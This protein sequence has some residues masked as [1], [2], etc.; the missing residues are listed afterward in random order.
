M[1]KTKEIVEII[2]SILP[3]RRPIE[4]HEPFI[5][6]YQLK[7]T[8][9][10][11]V[12]E[13]IL[14]HN[15]VDE[16]TQTISTIT[17]SE[18]C[19]LTN[20]GTAALEVA[21]RV[22]DVKP[23]EEVIVPS[24]TFVAT[25]NAVSHIGAVPH[26]V[27]G[28]P[29]LRAY[30]LRQYLS[31]KTVPCEG[32][33]VYISNRFEHQNNRRKI[34]AIVVVH[35]FGIP[36]AIEDICQV[37][38]EFNLKV[39]EDASQAFGSSINGKYCGTFG[40]IGTFS[41]NGNKIITTNG[42][43]AIVTNDPYLAAKAYQLI[44]TSKIPHKWF[45]D[46]DNIAW[47]Y[48]MGNVNAALGCSQLHDPKNGNRFS[49]ILAHKRGLAARYRHNLSHLVKFVEPTIEC[50]PNYWLNTILVDN[51]DE[52][53]AHLHDEGIKARAA[54][55]P[56]HRLPMYEDHSRSDLIMHEADDLFNRGICLPSGANL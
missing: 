15:Y 17:K 41:F 13:G 38:K 16:L 43:G 21:L 29:N 8:F 26:F 2:K 24:A 34:V 28:A 48:R 11:A 50:E 47:N 10:R 14:R 51:R 22:L 39:I 18:Q 42:G 7:D 40:D 53:L 37:A 54:F 30:K 23:D 44:T 46:H 5:D 6:N 33:R 55:T 3:K 49:E 1:Q 35:L 12:D 56:L 19:I 27:D 25:A 20:T 31:K 32:G 4:H 36:A 52:L 45:M 9:I